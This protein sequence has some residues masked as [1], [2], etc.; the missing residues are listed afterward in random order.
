[1][2]ML[3]G[4]HQQ[5]QLDEQCKLG[6]A[7]RKEFRDL[8]DTERNYRD[9]L[10]TN[11][12]YP[13]RLTE[14]VSALVKCGRYLEASYFF[15]ELCKISPHHEKTIRLGYTI[16]IASFDNDGILK[17]DKLLTDSDPD[18]SELLWFR[19]RY[20]Q[21]QNNIF[22]CVTVSRELLEKRLNP[23]YLSTILE[24]CIE[25]QSYA[26][27]EPL[28]RYLAKH[29]LAIAPPMS[30]WFKQIIIAK[31]IETLRGRK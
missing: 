14:Y 11:R 13:K 6:S 26:I 23:E 30:N 7:L 24:I 28:A 20:Y 18:I 2:D 22:Y 21:S 16:A 9:T 25:R 10:A 19:L 12:K 29:Q 3:R 5:A 15:L 31:L 27:A 8:E 17:Y 4:V 1:M